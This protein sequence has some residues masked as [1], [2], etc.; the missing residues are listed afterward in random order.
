M[1]TVWITGGGSGIGA[2]LARIYAAEG[3]R[4]VIS[5]RDEEKLKR[6]AE[7]VPNVQVAVCDVTVP[8]QV[9]T[10]ADVHGPFDIAVL[11]AGTYEPGPTHATSTEKF[12]RIMDVN[13]FGVLNC[14]QALLPGMRVRGGRLAIVASLA[15]YRGLPN[16]SGYGA[17][18]AALISLCESLRA[19]LQDTGVTVQVINPGF[20]KSELTDKNDFEM[21]Y[22]MEPEQA[23]TVIRAGLDQTG[24]EIAFP[25]PFVRRLKLLRLL[26]YWLF[27]K[28]MQ[29]V[30]AT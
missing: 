26:P 27:F 2:A 12:R 19:E 16:A 13:F 28:L 23:A 17:S 5:G 24:F 21:P 30:D 7:D 14:V 29:K 1:K 6:V 18:K 3:W 22:L 8:D 11:N 20:V 4:T 25:G 10:C 9:Q 15:G